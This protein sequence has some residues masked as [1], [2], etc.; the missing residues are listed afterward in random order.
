MQAALQ[1]SFWGSPDGQGRYW[2]D[3]LS[4]S[5]ELRTMI[6]AGRTAGEIKAAW[7]DDIAAFKARRKPYL[8][9]DE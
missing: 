5:A 2:I 7:Q 4:G 3:L 9:Y 1:E 6:E 8:L